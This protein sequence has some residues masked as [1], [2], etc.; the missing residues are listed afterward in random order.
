MTLPKHHQHV[1]FDDKS[2]S[3]SPTKQEEDDN[4]IRN[5]SDVKLSARLI[6]TGSAFKHAK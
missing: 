1:K 3:R 4:K 2:T 5:S 6:A